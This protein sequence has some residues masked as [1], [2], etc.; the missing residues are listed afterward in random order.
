MISILTNIF[1]DDIIHSELRNVNEYLIQVNSNIIDIFCGFIHNNLHYNLVSLFANDERSIKN[2][3]V[4]NYI[5]AIREQ[6]CL[7]IIKTN[8]DDINFKSI[9]KIIPAASLYELEIHDMFG[10]IPL[11][12][13]KIK[14]LVF[15]NNWP[16]KNNTYTNIFTKEKHFFP[17]RKDYPSNF[18]PEFDNI[19]KCEFSKIEG[20]GVY[21]IPVGPV[22]AGIIEPGHFRFSVVG[23]PIVN[24]EA[25][26]FFVHK[27]IEKIAENCTIEKCLFLSERISGDES[28]SNSL[29]YC[30]AIE[31][32]AKI[33]IPKRASYQRIIFA[34]IERITSH[35]G[36]LAGICLDVAYG[37]A[38]FQFKLLR[39]YMFQIADLLCGMRFLRSVNKI[40]GIRK[41]FLLGKE[42]E[43]I[44]RIESIKKELLDTQ[45]IL[46]SNSMFIDR[47]EN[48]G[49]LVNKIAQDLNTVGPCGRASG[50]DYDVRKSFPYELYSKFSFNI[51]KHNNG[52]VNCRMNTKLEECLESLDLIVNVINSSE[53]GEISSEIVS[54]P[55]FAEALSIIESPR[56]ENVHYVMTGENNTIFRYKIRTPSFCNWQSLVYAVKGNIVPDFPLINKSFNL[57]YSG[58]DL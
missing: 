58:N 16:A 41:D 43:V 35:L 24:L 10:L 50:I 17:L 44:T 31:K 51:P 4:L 26:L 29:A 54:V 8:L 34:E 18:K 11:D 6:G 40:G 32:I 37:F 55:P 47:I 36:D 33:Q 15:H 28:F 12:H 48:T 46:K 23:E 25:Q 53:I 3:Y 38:S 19:S 7:L 9:S 2:V 14:P 22:H 56:G 52:D 27:G 30:N 20:E 45:N 13:P 39:G 49:V 57:S 21:E 5:F 1:K 42:K